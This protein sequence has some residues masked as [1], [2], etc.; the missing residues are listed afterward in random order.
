MDAYF[1]IVCVFYGLLFFIDLY[2]LSRASHHVH[3]NQTPIAF[4]LCA[5][6][7]CGCIFDTNSRRQYRHHTPELDNKAYVLMDY[8]TG[9]ILAQKNADTPLPPASLTKMMTG[10][11]LEQKLLN[12][13]IKEDTPI[14]MSENAWC[15]G[16]GT[17]SCMYVE[18]NDSAHAIDML[19]GI[20]I[21]S[22]NDASKAVAEHIA[23]SEA[24]FATLMNEEAKKLGMTNTVF[25]N[26]TGMP[27]PNHASAKDLAVLSKAIIKNSGKYY[28]I[29]SE[30]E[31]TYN[32]I[33][34]GNR[35]TLL[36]A[37]CRWSKSWTHRRI[38]FFGG[39][40]QA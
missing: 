35:N 3:H 7:F 12:G 15:R 8:D 1:G 27:A 11:I 32:K 4:L 29:Y 28:P 24:A 31:Y 25:S 33:K 38:G 2:L 9:V 19:R 14:K 39:I 22:G 10:Y 30:K 17:Q 23:G 13:E 20:I 34:Q 36:S 40:L 16:S 21:Q 26:A 37:G 6:C 18:L 5:H